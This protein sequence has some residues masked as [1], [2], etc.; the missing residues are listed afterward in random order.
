MHCK[1][2]S[3]NFVWGISLKKQFS[4]SNILIP[5]ERLMFSASL[6]CSVHLSKTGASY[7]FLVCFCLDNRLGFPALPTCFSK[8]YSSGK[9]WDKKL[10]VGKHLMFILIKKNNDDWRGSWKYF[11]HLNNIHEI[12]SMLT[13]NTARLQIHFVSRVIYCWIFKQIDKN[14]LS[15]W[16]KFS[17]TSTDRDSNRKMERTTLL[18]S[19]VTTNL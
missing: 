2:C 6:K 1:N 11:I 14:I 19:Q 16:Q 13:K 9:Y 15:P 10:I 18:F 12:I 7:S 3:I 8:C 5:K 17:L 4:N